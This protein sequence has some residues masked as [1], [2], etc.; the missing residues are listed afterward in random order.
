MY[1]QGGIECIIRAL[2]THLRISSMA[3]EAC[4]CFANIGRNAQAHLF[5]P[6]D[7]MCSLSMFRKHWSQ[8]PGTPHI[9]EKKEVLEIVT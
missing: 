9:L 6:I 2:K 3:S 5:T 4:R 1:I 7:R 8:C